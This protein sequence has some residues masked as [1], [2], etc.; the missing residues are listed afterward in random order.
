[1]KESRVG[2]TRRPGYTA[3]PF[4]AGG[5]LLPMQHVH[6]RRLTRSSPQADAGET[7]IGSKGRLPNSTTQPSCMPPTNQ[8]ITRTTAAAATGGARAHRPDAREP[9]GSGGRGVA[10]HGALS[11]ACGT[12][13]RPP[14]L[15]RWER[16]GGG[17]GG[18]R[19]CQR[20]T[21]AWRRRRGGRAPRDRRARM[22]APG[23]PRRG[24]KPRIGAR[25]A[26]LWAGLGSIDRWVRKRG[27]CFLIAGR[28]A[29]GSDVPLHSSVWLLTK[30]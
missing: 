1:M 27:P 21:H 12:A 5:R 11:R 24:G 18:R 2:C 26:R 6:V 14:A 23:G 19:S 16:G 9:R 4:A 28:A 13:T 29:L 3:A 20:G 22:R 8:L 10:V 17:G 30:G 15:Q 25:A 7:R